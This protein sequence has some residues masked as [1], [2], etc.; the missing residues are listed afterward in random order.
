[1]LH[2]AACLRAERWNDTTTAAVHL[3]DAAPA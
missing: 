3:L 1:M 2:V